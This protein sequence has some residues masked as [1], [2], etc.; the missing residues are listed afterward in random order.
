M[1]GIVDTVNKF[2]QSSLCLLLDIE[3]EVVFDNLFV[4]DVSCL[5]FLSSA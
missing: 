3:S 2:S 1:N 4:S 5:A